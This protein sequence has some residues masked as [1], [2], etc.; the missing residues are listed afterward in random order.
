MMQQLLP[1]H[2]YIYQNLASSKLLKGLLLTST[3]TKESKCCRLAL[4]CVNMCCVYLFR[5][6]AGIYVDLETS[7]VPYSKLVRNQQCF[8]IHSDLNLSP[9]DWKNVKLLVTY[10]LTY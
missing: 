8:V 3:K 9:N 1:E 10:L 6:G 5:I 4:I 7:P 2:Q